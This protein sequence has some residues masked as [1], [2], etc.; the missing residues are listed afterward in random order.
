M[1][2]KPSSA[3][4]K[5]A[6][7]TLSV[8]TLKPMMN[9]L[10]IPKPRPRLKADMVEAIS[11]RLTGR[12]LRELWER[13]DKTQQLA[14]KE[15]LYG[16]EGRFEA[17][18]FRAKYGV[19]PK[20]IDKGDT[21]EPTLL[22]LFLY[23]PDGYRYFAPTTIPR[24]FVKQLREFVPE[25]EEPTVSAVDEIPEFIDRRRIA[26][27]PKGQ[28]PRFDRVLLT[29]RAMEQ[30]AAYDL[31][32]VLRLVDQGKISVSAKTRRA[33]AVSVRRIAEVLHGGD[34]FDPNQKKRK[35]WEQ[36]I[37]PIRAFAW[38][39]LVQAGKLVQ[40]RGSKLVLNKAGRAAFT[41]PPA[42]T[43]RRIWRWWL[44]STLLDEF[45]RME[46]IKGQHR[47]RGKRT[48]TAVR[49]RRPLIDEA[50]AECP[51]GDWVQVDEF[52]RFM[53]AAE[54]DVSVTRDPWR[55]YLVEMRH[56]SFGFAGNH[57]WSLLQGRYVLCLL[58]EYV[59]TLGLVDVAFT[60]P[61]G[62]RRDFRHMWGADDLEFLSRYDGLEYFRLNPL[63]AYCV[64]Q[65]DEYEPGSP[66][67]RTALT[68]YTDLRVESATPLP[69][70]E[71]V[72]LET[73][74][75]VESDGVW[76]L[77]LT[78]A[79]SAVESGQDVTQLREFLD[80]RDD[81]PLP[82]KVEGF[83]RSV[84]L[85]ARALKRK[86][87]ALLIECADKEIAER[88]AADRRA[89]KYCVRA[90]PRGLVVPARSEAAFRRAAHALGYALPLS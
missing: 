81:Q 79:L 10:S 90:G 20:R 21:T 72:V 1:R 87:P 2:I 4:L 39:W 53:E 26:F 76:R 37:G 31:F 61:H 71:L 57:E 6:L 80:A 63:G 28:K 13:L 70:E 89:A 9:L 77:D 59:A 41:A 47:G 69:P 14:V 12:S 42:E 45:S 22:H 18:R 86:G 32:A 68:L 60:D 29:R 33:S 43:R 85:G 5:Q 83:I 67:I 73:Y 46:D 64:G 23:P 56:G 66:P 62:A 49:H 54:L 7:S 30:P 44:K 11:L 75:R 35:S 19:L 15:A 8:P 34:F 52:F 84:E 38:P 3:T 55:L 25:P 40:R 74:A 50:L 27:V 36:T 17:K 65:T 78:R 48:M 58:F 16:L 24:D 51:V 88:I 82:E